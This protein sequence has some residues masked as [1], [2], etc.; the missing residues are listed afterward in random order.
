M[1]PAGQ[2]DGDAEDELV[3]LT[4]QG[5][6]LLNV[7]RVDRI[8]QGQYV[9][10]RLYD[11]TPGTFSMVDARVSLGDVDNDFRDEIFVVARGA[12]FGL[13][14]NRGQVWDSKIPWMAMERY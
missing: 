10:E 2:L 6:T 5:P 14:S 4:L 9:R 7:H 13:N 1:R 12:Q 11:V 8:G 3:V